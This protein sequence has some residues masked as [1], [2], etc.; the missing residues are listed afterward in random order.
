MRLGADDVR[1][2]AAGYAWQPVGVD[3][4]DNPVEPWPALAPFVP[5]GV[6][7]MRSDAYDDAQAQARWR[8]VYFDPARSVALFELDDH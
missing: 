8:R 3:K 2:L 7:W 4:P 6:R 1:A 5:S